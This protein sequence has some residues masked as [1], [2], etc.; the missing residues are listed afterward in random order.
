MMEVPV[1]TI[2]SFAG[3]IEPGT[4]SGTA[5]D[6]GG[7]PPSQ[8]RLSDA[9]WLLCDGRPVYQSVYPELFNVLQYAYGKQGD[10][11]FCLPDL[12]GRFL[13]GVNLGAPAFDGVERAPDEGTRLASSTGGNTGGQV[14]SVQQDALQKHE[15]VYYFM[16]TPVSPT[17]SEGSPVLS[18]AP[19]SEKMATLTGSA[20]IAESG[21]GVGPTSQAVG[22]AGSVRAADETVA[23][24]V[25]VNFLIKYR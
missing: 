13:R 17:V 15:H 3:P 23:K 24:N 8:R 2:V 10:G 5:R 4:A 21:I 25:Y 9:G 7:L 22:G 1:G 14:G 11:V 19:P 16:P 12:R 18:D 6:P 20:P